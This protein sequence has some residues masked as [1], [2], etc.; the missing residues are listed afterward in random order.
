MGSLV[1]VILEELVEPA[2]VVLQRKG[3]P[4]KSWVAV[5]IGAEKPAHLHKP[6]A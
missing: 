2:A 5:F 4:M 1:D 3:N 6:G